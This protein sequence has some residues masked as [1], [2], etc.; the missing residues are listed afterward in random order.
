[1]PDPN[2]DNDND[3]LDGMCSDGLGDN[4]PTADDDAPYVALFADLLGPD[5]QVTDQDALSRE[6]AE[7]DELLNSEPLGSGPD[8]DESG[9]EPL[10][11]GP[12]I[13]EDGAPLGVG[14]EA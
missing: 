3:L 7:W 11:E 1:M 6:T 12:P 8:I 10:G 9:G 13:V 4:P 14:E 5:G 2:D